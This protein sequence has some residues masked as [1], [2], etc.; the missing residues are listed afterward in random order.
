VIGTSQRSRRQQ[1]TGGGSNVMRVLRE[2]GPLGID[3]HVIVLS[4]PPR[5][6]DARPA[7]QDEK[8]SRT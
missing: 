3:V 1:L 2:A 5:S 6:Q 4:K 8:I 7:R